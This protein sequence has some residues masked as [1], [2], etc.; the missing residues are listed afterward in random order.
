MNENKIQSEIGKSSADAEIHPGVL[1]F[2]TGPTRRSTEPDRRQRVRVRCSK[3]GE[4]F[5]SESVNPKGEPLQAGWTN[6]HG[7]YRCKE[8]SLKILNTE[9]LNNE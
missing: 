9:V 3:C 7:L 5:Q 1:H 8:C 6:E 2:V 4:Y